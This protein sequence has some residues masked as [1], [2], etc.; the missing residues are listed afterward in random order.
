VS[1]TIIIPF[2]SHYA[3]DDRQPAVREIINEGAVALVQEFQRAKQFNIA[4]A[5]QQNFVQNL[6]VPDGLFTKP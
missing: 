2:L 1:Y 5:Y 3:L 4:R 6:Q